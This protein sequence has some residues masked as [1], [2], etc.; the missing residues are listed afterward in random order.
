MTGRAKDGHV[1]GASIKCLSR[2]NVK[3]KAVNEAAT[4]CT[5]VHGNG[6]HGCSWFLGGTRYDFMPAYPT[7][8]SLPFRSSAASAVSIDFVHRR[9]SPTKAFRLLRDKRVTLGT[10]KG[11]RKRWLESIRRNAVGIC[12][13]VRLILNPPAEAYP[14][15]QTPQPRSF[16]YL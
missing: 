16:C 10:K 9:M 8:P 7:P 13:T 2:Q 1:P 3:R 4:Y 15:R 6:H 12:D 14:Y 11:W 5:A